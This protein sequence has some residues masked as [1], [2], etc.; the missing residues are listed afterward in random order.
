MYDHATMTILVAIEAPARMQA[1]AGVLNS[2]SDTY[3]PVCVSE[4]SQAEAY[5][6]DREP[7]VVVTDAATPAVAE[8]LRARYPDAP[9]VLVAERVE[10]PQVEV[11][12]RTQATALVRLPCD[13]STVRRVFD[14]PVPA[15][16]FKGT[17][18]GVSTAMLLALHCGTGADG[19]LYL[20]RAEDGASG[21]IYL[22]GGQPIHAACGAMA[23]PDAVKEMLRWHDAGARFIAGRTGAARTVVGRWEA[24]LAE[25][26]RPTDEDMLPVAIPQV[27]EKLARLSQTPD[28]LGAFLIRNAEIITGR[29]VAELDDKVVGRALCRLSNVYADVDG[30]DTEDAGR[31]IQATLGSVRLVVDRLGPKEMGYQVGVVVRQASPVCK[32]L[33]RLLRQIDRSFGRALAKGA[34]GPGGRLAAA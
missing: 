21:C 26:R 33:R 9:L 8:A 13:A 17:C 22:E 2:A 27:M 18:R 29:C 12:V 16:E 24:V 10:T 31:E 23:G 30:L 7:A 3:S 15:K 34:N 14:V 11:A 5:F 19:V 4:P 25:R 20:V 32:S 1:F 6:A 28:I